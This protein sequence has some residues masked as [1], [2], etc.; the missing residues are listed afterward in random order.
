MDGIHDP[1][2]ATTLQFVV[3]LHDEMVE[4]LREIQKWE[5]GLSKPRAV[6]EMAE[7]ARRTLAK[8]EKKE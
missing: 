7:I 4:A 6:A 3:N 8:V 1:K 2:T 5:S